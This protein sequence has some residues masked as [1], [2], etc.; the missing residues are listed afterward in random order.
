LGIS[1]SVWPG[2]VGNVDLWARDPDPLVDT[3]LLVPREENA[4]S[5]GI[6]VA[7]Y[8]FPCHVM[9]LE[10]SKSLSHKWGFS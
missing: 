3:D 1:V 7:D 6:I 10:L 2:V 4:P 8:F 9:Y 5:L